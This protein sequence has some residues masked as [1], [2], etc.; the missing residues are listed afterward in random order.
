LI[1]ALEQ[2]ERS[3][4]RMAQQLDEL[5]DAA[6]LEA[7][8]PLELRRELTDLM[9]LARQ[10]IAEHQQQT[11]RHDLALVAVMPTLAGVWDGVRL[12]RVLDN[13]LGNAVKYSPLGGPIQ[14][15]VG[16]EGDG[17]EQVALV[18]V[19]DRGEGIPEQDLPFIFERFRRGANVEG[20]IPGTGIGLAGVRRIVEQHGG[21]IMVESAIGQGTTVTVRLPLNQQPVPTDRQ[22]D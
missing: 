8:R 7:G 20:R 14:L 2:I 9:A 6:R 5:V 13:L 21:S 17:A 12:G 22:H 3:A 16:T 18:R 1:D 19:I 11:D 10:V 15:C 4:A